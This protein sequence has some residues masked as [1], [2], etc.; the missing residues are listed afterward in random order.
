MGAAALIAAAVDPSPEGQAIDAI[1]AYGTYDSVR[2]E[3]QFVS[4]ERFVAPLRFVIQRLGLP[5]ASAQ[6]GADLNDFSP[7]TLVHDLWPRPIM[8]IHGL[9]DQIIAFQRGQRLFDS[10]QQPKQR[11]WIDRAGHNDIINDENVAQRVRQF[12]QNA[13]PVPVI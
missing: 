9:N 3:L 13:E 10:A 6:V 5:L 1:A 11:L 8:V 12:F 4:E 2:A 7:A